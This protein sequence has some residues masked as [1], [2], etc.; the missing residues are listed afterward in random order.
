[1]LAVDYGSQF[2]RDYKRCKR[3]H[4]PMDE[5]HEVIRLVAEN[6]AAS[7]EEL[8]RHHNMHALKGK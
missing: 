7:L 8:R 1:M 3:K 5:L 2:K 6:S 4:L